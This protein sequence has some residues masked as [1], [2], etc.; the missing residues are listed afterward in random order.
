MSSRSFLLLKRLLFSFINLCRD[1]TANR[2]D[3]K[4]HAVI[5]GVPTG[6]E[7]FHSTRHFVAVL[8]F[9]SSGA[10]GLESL[11]LQ[12]KWS[13]SFQFAGYYAAQ[14]LGYYREA[15]LDVSLREGKPGLDVVGEVSS[16]RADFG[17]GTSSLL[18]ARHAGKPVVALA[19][20]AGVGRSAGDP[21]AP[22]VATP[23]SPALRRAGAA[24]RPKCHPAGAKPDRYAG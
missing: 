19:A 12:L 9:F 1:C 22:G 24:R 2:E 11:S 6:P 5:P 17:V 14:D 8:L 13:H 3:K 16:G 21:C 7:R 15:G 10:A 18:L 20:V 4:N 23:G